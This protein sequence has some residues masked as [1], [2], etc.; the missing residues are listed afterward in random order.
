MI[1]GDFILLDFF[2]LNTNSK[3]TQITNK[4]GKKKD[5]V[6]SQLRNVRLRFF[7][8][9]K[10]FEAV[11]SSSFIP[12]VFLTVDLLYLLAEL[13]INLFVFLNLLCAVFFPVL[14]TYESI[15]LFFISSF[16]NSP[17]SSSLTSLL[18]WINS[19]ELSS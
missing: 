15:N 10:I 12:E 13:P 2:N 1:G 14:S 11:I 6:I 8:S 4:N 9:L 3:T 17:L 16:P 19:F 7:K 5:E 18:C